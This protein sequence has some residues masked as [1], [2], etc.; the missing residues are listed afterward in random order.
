MPREVSQRAELLVRA[1]AKINL[2]LDVL[3]KRPDGFHEI[4]T[5]MQAV[6]L[7]DRLSFARRADARVC[8]HCS[9][10]EVPDGEDNLI[11]RAA[12]LLRLRSGAR[13]GAEIRLQKHIPV[14]GGL[15]GGSSNAAITLLALN[16]LWRVRLNEGELM[17][18]AASLGSDVA[19]FVRGGTAV[20][21]GRGQRVGVP[22]KG[23]RIY[24][25]LAMPEVAVSTAAVYAATGTGLTSPGAD[26]NN[27]LLEAL[28]TGDVQ[29]LTAC[30]RNQLQQPALELH[31]CLRELLERLN[32][33]SRGV[34][35]RRFLLSGSGSTFF[36]IAR[37]E[38]EAAR[39]SEALQAKLGVRCIATH[40]LPA[41][42][43]RVDKLIIRRRHL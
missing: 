7:Y 16:R 23:P 40:S 39:A 5:V 12:R 4:R 24:H 11:V 21:K 34:D 42:N 29:A 19:F 8:L 9:G 25:V 35:V 1:P 26:S 43:G 10:S 33:E 14:G 15:G 18:L 38:D 6:S 20:C 31:D 28:R 22:L 2:S 37:C 13:A 27:V 36:G 17:E 3:G 30:L 32:R 41:W